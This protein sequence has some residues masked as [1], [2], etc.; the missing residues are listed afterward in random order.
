MN[1]PRILLGQLLFQV[2]LVSI[3]AV[4]V[5][6]ELRSYLAILFPFQMADVTSIPCEECYLGATAEHWC[7]PCG[8]PICFSCT[9]EKHKGHLISPINVVLSK[10]GDAMV[11]EMSLKSLQ[12]R[13]LV[14]WKDALEMAKNNTT[15]YMYK[16]HWLEKELEAT[17]DRMH[18]QV[19]VLLSDQQKILKDISEHNLAILQKQEKYLGDR[20]KKLQEKIKQYSDDLLGKSDSN[21]FQKFKLGTILQK[22]KKPP[23]I[24]K[25]P[26][27]LLSKGDIDTMAN[28]FGHIS[29]RTGLLPNPSE[30]LQLHISANSEAVA[31]DNSGQAWVATKKNTIKLMNK[32]KEVINTINTNCE[33]NDMA[34]SSAGDI[35]F[36]DR[37][38]DVCVKSLSLDGKTS[39]LFKTDMKPDGICCLKNGDIV[40]TFPYAR[41]V[42]KYSRTGVAKQ[43]YDSIMLHYPR[44]VAGSKLNNDLYL[45]DQ[46]IKNRKMP[47]RILALEDEGTLKFEYPD[48]EDLFNPKDV[49]AD[50]KGHI[51]IAMYDTASDKNFVHILDIQG[52]ILKYLSNTMLSDIFLSCIDVDKHGYVWVTGGSRPSSNNL[53]GALLRWRHMKY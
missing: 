24:S 28:A 49:C 7:N 21:T 1:I 14:E 36:T 27:L 47:S 16:V 18:K 52:Y 37:S 46:D 4:R 45:V 13:T 39:T 11:K 3:L 31:C 8:V 44:K 42:I 6:L 12:E 41:K 23:P 35:I 32:K 9:T 30:A 22:E 38:L 48:H 26:S 43:T 29:T 33:I 20:V 2:L 51:I 5:F 10:P 40:V 50:Q 53:R 15:E 17:A 25:A 19:D 34:L